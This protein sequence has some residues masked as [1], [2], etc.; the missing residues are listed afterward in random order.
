LDTVVDEF[1]IVVAGAGIAGLTAGLSSARLGS[2]T[3]VLTGGVPGGLLLSID[4]IDGLP[5]FPNGVPGYELCPLVQ[6]QASAAGAEFSMAELEAF[7]AGGAGWRVVTSEGEIG[8]KA[9]ILATGARFRELGVPGEERLRGHGVSHCASCDAPLLR[10]RVAAVVGG[11]DSALQEALTLAESVAAVIVL[12]HDD[13][14]SA[15]ETYRRAALEQPKIEIRTGMLVEEIIGDERV[16]GIRTRT[17]ATGAVEDVKADAVFAYIGLEPNTL[18]TNGALEL[19]GEGRIPTDPSMRSAVPGVFAAGIVRRGA[20]GR[21]AGSAGDG[22][23][24]A[25]AAHRYLNDGQ[26]PAGKERPVP[27]AV[28]S[29][30]ADG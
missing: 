12:Q 26:W 15:Q 10:E 25:I 23:T 3:L 27:V 2:R 6:E 20:P 11:G 17:V 22:A 28:A 19:D 30:D 4:R 9:L 16:A 14:L 5:G 18:F 13:E 21:A 29:G 7:E 8:A 24:A 1:D